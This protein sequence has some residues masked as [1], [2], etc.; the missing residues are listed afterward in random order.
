MVVNHEAWIV[1][2]SVLVAIQ[3]AY[4]GLNLAL[5]LPGST[6]GRRRLLL[7]GAA[8][9][10][11]VAIW[12][13]HFLG[14]LAVRSPIHID[15]HAL[16]T[17]VSFLVC[18]LVVGLAVFLA[19]SAP[20]SNPVLG[21]AAA[22][23]GAGIVSM[24][25]I[26]MLALHAQA[27]MHHDARYVIAS[28]L[29]GVAASRLA[30]HFAFAGKIRPPL[31]AASIALGLAISGMHY[32]AMAG[33]TL[34]AQAELASNGATTLSGDLLAVIVATVAFGSSFA[35]FLALVPDGSAGAAK[36][37]M[38][39]WP[40]RAG[41]VVAAPGND[42][43]AQ[44][45]QGAAGP[46]RATASMLI[47]VQKDGAIYY[48]PAGRVHAVKADAHYTS[49]FDGTQEFFCALSISDV[50]HR[51]DQSRFIRVH[52]SH[53]VALDHIQSLKK[54][55]DGGIAQLDSPTRYTLP[56]SR[57]KLPELKSILRARL[58]PRRTEVAAAGT[59]LRPLNP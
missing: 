18:V 31:L 1:A 42:A 54:A 57:R 10:L 48:L 15:Y 13:M 40:Q 16:P 29:I 59:D 12:S 32:T 46:P 33:M 44:P 30:L 34:H 38:A 55:G 7:A 28:F 43:S 50:E 20:S 56:V 9:T 3:G 49:V 24:H 5:E 2:L 25:F 23:M 8:L 36:P 6:G 41:P 52:R 27:V 47:P 37:A 22:V 19:S 14:M 35:F 26:G 58:E 11:A 45:S 53:I 39:T 4:V 17:L 21:V 51:L